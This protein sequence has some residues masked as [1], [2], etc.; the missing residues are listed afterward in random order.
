M[1]VGRRIAVTGALTGP[2]AGVHRRT[3]YTLIAAA[4]GRPVKSVS[5]RTDLLVCSRR[6]TTKSR[7][8]AA[9]GI[10]V[11]NPTELALLLGYPALW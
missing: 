8:A 10:S 11:I 1:L 6:P 3:A 2:L 9:L 5:R 4:G 7:R